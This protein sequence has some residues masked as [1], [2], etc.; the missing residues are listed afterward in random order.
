MT[1]LLVILCDEPCPAIPSWGCGK[2]KGHEGPH[3]IQLGK[4][5]PYL[6]FKKC[7]SIE[8]HESADVLT[9]EAS[10]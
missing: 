8:W 4:Y 1:H 6:G 3:R 2:E 10:P 9:A 5:L 7:G